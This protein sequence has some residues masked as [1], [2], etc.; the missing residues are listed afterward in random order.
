MI[1]LTGK[2]Y[3]VGHRWAGFI[4]IPQAQ[5]GPRHAHRPPF[6]DKKRKKMMNKTTELTLLIR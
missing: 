1:V 2:L 3:T 5:S 4:T 6:F